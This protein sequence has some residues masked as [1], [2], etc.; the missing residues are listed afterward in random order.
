MAGIGEPDYGALVGWNVEC[1]GNRVILKLQTVTKP[2][3]HSRKDVREE[4]IFLD[5]NQAVQLGNNLFTMTGQTLPEPSRH[6]NKPLLR[7]L[8]GG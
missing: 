3:P 4:F 2:A 7:R 6:H 1:T 5:R 8:L